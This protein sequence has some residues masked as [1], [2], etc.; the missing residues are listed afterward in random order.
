MA[1]IRFLG[2][3]GWIHFLRALEKLPSLYAVA[4]GWAI[5]K[6]NINEKIVL[7]RSCSF[8]FSGWCWVYKYSSPISSAGWEI[9][10]LCEWM[11]ACNFHQLYD[12]NVWTS[13]A[14]NWFLLCIE[15]YSE[16]IAHFV[17]CVLL[18]RLSCLCKS[19]SFCFM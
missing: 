18:L 2:D 6:R 12:D 7:Y 8:H 19:F 15:L 4:V 16:A 5:W 13:Y 17:H 9:M 1:C 14:T 11:G 10:C 3:T